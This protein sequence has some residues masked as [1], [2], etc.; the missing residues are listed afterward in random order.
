MRLV[1]ADTSPIFTY[2]PS[3]TLTSCRGC[4]E[5]C[6]FPMPC[7][8]SCAILRPQRWFVNGW[9]VFPTGRL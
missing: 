1:V 6:L 8:M 5:K 3:I 2:C 4:L 9:R 7:M